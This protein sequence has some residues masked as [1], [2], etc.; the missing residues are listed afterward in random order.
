M[1]LAENINPKEV[2]DKLE[3]GPRASNNSEANYCLSD[4]LLGFVD[5]TLFS[6]SQDPANATIEEVEKSREAGNKENSGDGFADKVTEISVNGNACLDF[7]FDVYLKW[8]H[9]CPIRR[10]AM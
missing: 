4:S 9:V 1:L 8:S 2:G 6:S 10:L 3:D 7:W 5:L